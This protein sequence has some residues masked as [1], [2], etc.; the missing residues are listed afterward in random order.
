[1]IA[2][3]GSFVRESKAVVMFVML[4]YAEASGFFAQVARCFGVPQHDKQQMHR[5]WLGRVGLCV[6]V[7]ATHGQ[8]YLPMPPRNWL[9]RGLLVLALTVAGCG[10]HQRAQPVNLSKPQTAAVEYVRA[11]GRGD[12]ATARSAAMGSEEEMR[13]VDALSSLVDGLRQLNSA[14]YEYFGPRTGQIHTDLEESI[15]ILADEPVELISNGGIQMNATQAVIT[16]RRQG[17]TSKD[18]LPIAVTKLADRQIWKVDLER[19]YVPLPPRERLLSMSEQQK[20][21]F[22]KDQRKQ[23]SQAMHKYQQI[24]DVF[25]GV[26]RDVRAKKFKT[27]EDF[28]KALRDRMG[29]LKLDAG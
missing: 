17:F 3:M 5:G 4:R 22:E 19:T 24:A 27:M 25:H 18:Q 10:P 1:M 9:A 14:L 8:E 20:N 23:I 13:W 15:R 6:L 7:E 28:E 12:S 11:I 29:D 21:D 26:A 16:P 2:A